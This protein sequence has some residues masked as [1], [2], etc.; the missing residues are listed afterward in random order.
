MAKLE[1]ALIPHDRNDPDRAINMAQSARLRNIKAQGPC[2]IAK[3]TKAS[4]YTSEPH[5]DSKVV[6]HVRFGQFGGS[7]DAYESPMDRESIHLNGATNSKDRD[8]GKYL[9]ITEVGQHSFE[10]RKMP[11]A[12]LHNHLNGPR[13]TQES[14]VSGL[15][16]ALEDKLLGAARARA[17]KKTKIS[18]CLTDR[19]PSK[20]HTFE[21]PPEDTN[22]SFYFPNT[23]PAF[24]QMLPNVDQSAYSKPVEMKERADAL[25]KDAFDSKNLVRHQAHNV[26]PALKISKKNLELVNEAEFQPEDASVSVEIVVKSPEHIFADTKDETTFQTQADNTIDVSKT[27]PDLKHDSTSSPV[28]AFTITKDTTATVI[29]STL[30]SSHSASVSMSSSSVATEQALQDTPDSTF[31]SQSQEVLTQSRGHTITRTIDPKDLQPPTSSMARRQKRALKAPK[32]D[33]AVE[34]NP[35]RSARLAA[36]PKPASATTAT[37]E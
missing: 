22:S 21:H 15:D 37:K 4:E 33:A 2:R 30:N 20:R 31:F 16:I 9:A 34:I 13:D 5:R 26:V 14:F 12:V 24:S 27:Y 8:E 10:S 17:P 32:K 35:R 18:A 7:R 29:S 1:P 11:S 28:A 6:P 3:R 19:P 36:K 23:T 25:V